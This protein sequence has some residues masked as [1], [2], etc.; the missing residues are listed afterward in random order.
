[1]HERSSGTDAGLVS[2][3]DYQQLRHSYDAL[4]EQFTA[5]DK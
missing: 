4:H 3:D 2:Q 1:M 5:A